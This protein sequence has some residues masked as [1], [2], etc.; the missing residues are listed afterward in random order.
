VGFSSS[1]RVLEGVSAECDKCWYCLINSPKWQMSR[2]VLPFLKTFPMLADL[3]LFTHLLIVVF[4]VGGLIAIWLGAALG[5]GWI[6]NRLFRFTHIG[7]MG[8]IAAEAI[9]GVTCPLTTLENLLRGETM[10]KGFIAQWVHKLMYYDAPPWVFTTSYVAFFAL[11]ALTW[12]SIPPKPA[13][14]PQKKHG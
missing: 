3:I 2:I 14:S 6:R 8:F 4:N 12:W 9:L 7:L 5:W 11:V 1:A 10:N 13:L